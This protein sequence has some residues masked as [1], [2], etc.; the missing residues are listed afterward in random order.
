MKPLRILVVEDDGM[1]ALTLAEMLETQG[2]NVLGIATTESEA[3]AAA[4]DLKPEMMIV[5]AQL[6]QGG[7]LGAVDRIQQGARIPHVFISGDILPIRA[8][9]PWATAIQKPF[10]EADLTCAIQR[11]LDAAAAIA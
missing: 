5:D 3:V 2:H 4:R 6:R 1:V 11:A 10:F 7:G 9:R 8:L